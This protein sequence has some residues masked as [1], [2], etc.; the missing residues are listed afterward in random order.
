MRGETG[1]IPVFQPDVPTFDLAMHETILER[2]TAFPDLVVNRVAHEA[3]EKV[4]YH[5]SY[6]CDGCFYNPVHA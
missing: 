2:L 4:F 6:K 3:F 1:E 5:M